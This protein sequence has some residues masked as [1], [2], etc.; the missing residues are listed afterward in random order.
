MFTR[1]GHNST[2]Y[3]IQNKKT[4]NNVSYSKLYG[5]CLSLPATS[6]WRL[7]QLKCNILNCQNKPGEL[8]NEHFLFGKFYSGLKKMLEL[9]KYLLTLGKTFD[10]LT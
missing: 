6:C 2:G 9:E 1:T 8:K 4:K 3:S 7:T 10:I 5:L